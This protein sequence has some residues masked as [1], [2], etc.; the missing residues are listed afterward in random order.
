MDRAVV[1]VFTYADVMIKAAKRLKDDGYSVTMQSPVPLVHEIEHEMG[2]RFDFLRF[3]TLFGGVGGFFGGTVF[4]LGT[5]VLYTMP[6]GGRPIFA[7]T[8]TLV[9]SYES[10]ILA[11]VLWTLMGFLILCRLPYFKKKVFVEKTAVDQFGLI[12]DGVSNERFPSVEKVL[13]EYG[14]SEVNWVEKT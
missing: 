3:F 11:G 1:G 5:A 13:T 4:A 7:A 9:I 6:R 8:P 2:R 12:V 10:T 14:A